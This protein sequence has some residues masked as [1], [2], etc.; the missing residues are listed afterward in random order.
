PI[1]LVEVQAYASAAFETMSRFATQR[2]LIEDAARYAGRAAKIRRCV[3]EKYWM[4][5]SE[6]YGIALDGHGD[7]CRVLASNAGHLLAFGLPEY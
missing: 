7:L 1:A 5:E 4:P 6:F 2:G 3:E